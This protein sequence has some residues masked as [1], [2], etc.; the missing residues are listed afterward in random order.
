MK[1]GFGC[2]CIETKVPSWT[3][4]RKLN[5]YKTKPKYETNRPTLKV[6]WIPKL[7]GMLSKNTSQKTQQKKTNISH[8]CNCTQRNRE[9]IKQINIWLCL[10]CITLTSCDPNL[11]FNLSTHIDYNLTV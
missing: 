5:A 6:E 4:E 10:A 1:P 11:I 2:Y 8:S 9:S 3:C 7:S